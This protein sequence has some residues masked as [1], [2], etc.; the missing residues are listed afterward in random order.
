MSFDNYSST[1][2]F[3]GLKLSLPKTYRYVSRDEYGFV[4]MW[5][6]KPSKEKYGFGNG[7]ELPITCGHQR[8]IDLKVNLRKYRSN[9]SSGVLYITGTV[10]DILP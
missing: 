1:I 5:R 7:E 6:S 4:Q 9:A 8:G 2:D 10:C 3:D